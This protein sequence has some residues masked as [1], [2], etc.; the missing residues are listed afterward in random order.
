MKKLNFLIS[1]L[2]IITLFIGIVLL[3]NEN[4]N[5]T[6]NNNS[7]YHIVE[8]SR[9]P[10]L[11]ANS[12]NWTF[13]IYLDADCNLES[14]GIE[15]INEMEMEGSDDNINIVVQIDRILGYALSNGDWTGTRRF[16]ITKDFDTDIIS[17]N[18]VR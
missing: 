2:L 17:S 1:I 11:S 6:K 10:K 16:Y 4:S 5:I 13:M 12:K 8:T 14:A 3:I 18:V 15:D 9:N 7:N